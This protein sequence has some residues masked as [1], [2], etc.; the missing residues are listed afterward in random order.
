ML[1]KSKLLVLQLQQSNMA[2]TVL[3]KYAQ[4]GVILKEYEDNYKYNYVKYYSVDTLE[5]DTYM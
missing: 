4:I 1:Y 2:K 5:M 3:I